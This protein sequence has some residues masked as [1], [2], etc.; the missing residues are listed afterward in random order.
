MRSAYFSI[1]FS[2]SVSSRLVA[3]ACSR[4]KNAAPV[5]VGKKDTE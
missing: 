3:I 4:S 5:Q 1:L 2:I